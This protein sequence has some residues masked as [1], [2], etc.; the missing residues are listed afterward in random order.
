MENGSSR[1][2]PANLA[3]VPGVRSAGDV[4]HNFDSGEAARL[5]EVVAG[6]GR[7]SRADKKVDQ[8]GTQEGDPWATPANQV[9]LPEVTQKL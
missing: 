2:T 4:E 7:G 9:L 8:E 5:R 1:A 3:L 6:Q